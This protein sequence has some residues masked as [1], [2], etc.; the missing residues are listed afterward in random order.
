MEILK[1][2]VCK[3]HPATMKARSFQK[4]FQNKLY[5]KYGSHS[6]MVSYARVTP[7]LPGEKP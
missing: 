6:H 1:D 3:E 4:E 7:G 2:H 5:R